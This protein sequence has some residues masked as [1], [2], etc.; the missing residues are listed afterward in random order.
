MLYGEILKDQTGEIMGKGEG[1]TFLKMSNR[2]DVGKKEDF[3]VMEIP[4]DNSEP[5]GPVTTA[6]KE[7]VESMKYMG[8][9]VKIIWEL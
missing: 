8:N 5:L 7:Q 9:L 3:I 2:D 1:A 4:Y 6:T